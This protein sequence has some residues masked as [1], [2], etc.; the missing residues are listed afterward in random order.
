MGVRKQGI[1]SK[2]RPEEARDFPISLVLII[3]SGHA[4]I[5]LFFFVF[6]LFCEPRVYYVE[7]YVPKEQFLTY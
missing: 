4:T 7:N 5:S 2:G 1:S 3:F 6:L